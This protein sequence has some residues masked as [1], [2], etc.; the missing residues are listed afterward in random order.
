MTQRCE[1]QFQ[2]PDGNLQWQELRDV[3]SW[4]EQAAK[5]FQRVDNV[6]YKASDDDII[7][8]GLAVPEETD[9]IT[10]DIPECPENYCVKVT[11]SAITRRSQSDGGSAPEL[12]YAFSNHGAYEDFKKM[13]RDAIRSSN[14]DHIF[15]TNHFL[16]CGCESFCM[17]D[18]NTE[19]YVP[20]D[21]TCYVE[22]LCG[23]RVFQIAY[24]DDYPEEN[25]ADWASTGTANFMDWFNECATAMYGCTEH[26]DSDRSMFQGT[27]YTTVYEPYWKSYPK[28]F[29]FESWLGADNVYG[30]GG[31]LYD[32]F[33]DSTSSSEP[34]VAWTCP[35][36]DHQAQLAYF[37]NFVEQAEFARDA[38]L[39][40]ILPSIPCEPEI[41]DPPEPPVLP[42]PTGPGCEEVDHNGY[43]TEMPGATC[44][45]AQASVTCA[46][47]DFVLVNETSTYYFDDV[48]DWT[49]ACLA[50]GVNCERDPRYSGVQGTLLYNGAPAGYPLYIGL[51]SNTSAC[52]SKST[53][54]VTVHTDSWASENNWKL[55]KLKIDGEWEEGGYVLEASNDL[56]YN[57]HLHEDILCLESGRTYRWTLFDSYGD[58]LCSYQGCGS[59]SVTL[60]GVE[61][62]SGDEFDNQV[63]EEFTTPVDHSDDPGWTYMLGNRLNDNRNTLDGYIYYSCESWEGAYGALNFTEGA[64]DRF[65]V[66]GNSYGDLFEIESGEGCSFSPTSSPSESPSLSSEPSNA[67]T[68]SPTLCGESY[69]TSENL[70]VALVVDLSYSTYEKEFSSSVDI[71]D[72]NGDGKGNTI[73]DAQIVAIQD[74]LTSIAESPTLNNDNCEIELISF[75][76]DA[77]DHG[78]WLP[79][80]DSG[81]GF[82]ADL[83][84]Y[85]K[86][87]LRAPTSNDDIFATNNGF[88][89]F[90]NAL[91]VTVDYFQNSAT[92][93]R[94]NLLVF[95]SDGEPNV[96]GDG[97]NEGY[98][99][100]T[101]VFWNGDDTVLQ[102]SDLGLA[103][104]ERHEICR[105]D[106]PMCVEFEP[107]Q[108]CVRGPNECM[109]ADAV[110]Q[111]DSEISALE[112]LNV[113]RLAI[114][115]GDESN[116]AW[117]SALWMID[118]NPGKDLGVLPLKAL[119]LEEL[120]EY[121]SSL[122]ILNTDPPTGSPS[123]SP[124]ASPTESSAPSVAPSDQP[125]TPAPTVTPS[126]LPYF[127]ITT[128]EPTVAPSLSPTNLPTPDPT[129]APSSTPTTSEPTTSPTAS[130]SASPT[131]APTDSPTTTPSAAPSGSFIPSLFPTDSPTTSS[132]PSNTPT[133]SPSEIP[134]GEPTGSPSASPSD[135][136]TTS[137]SDGPTLTPSTFPT[138]DP[139]ASFEPTYV[140][141]DCFEGPRMV[142]ADSSDITMC[143][144]N[145]DM[146]QIN[147]MSTTDVTVQI[148]NVWTRSALPEQL[149]VFAHTDSIDAILDRQDGNGF[150]CLNNDG[151]D[152]DIEGENELSVQC[153]Q[154]SEDS[155]W[156]AVI[157][158]VIT[159]EIICGTNDVPHPCFP[160]EGPILESCS[161]RIIIPCE[162]EAIC[163]EEPTTSPSNSPTSEPTVSPTDYPTLS[164]TTSPTA[165]PTESPTSSPTSSPTT[166]PT[167]GPTS[168]PTESPIAKPTTEPTARFTQLEGSEDNDDYGFPPAECPDDIQ[169]IQH[170]GV[171]DLPDHAVRIVSQDNSTVTVQLVQAYTNAS[172]A[173]GSWYYQYQQGIFSNKCY[174]DTNVVGDDIEEIT[175]QCTHH[176]QIALLEFWISDDI[177]NGVLAEGD[178][179]VIPECCH[180]SEPDGTPAT[181]YVI[182]IRCETACPEV[183]E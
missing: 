136:P 20:Y 179:A 48:A 75:E 97:D 57:H 93:N 165:V 33:P 65:D 149:R 66:F 144:Y 170:T 47:V 154:E 55:E 169:V 164:P 6:G 107:L 176:N 37:G 77:K 9:L 181:R 153:F 1:Y 38:G 64:G 28:E 74:L 54:N 25:K 46:E 95:L 104:G 19:D 132:K 99:T 92:P 83:M 106:D 141:P 27:G 5:T 70:N 157:D 16:R 131:S 2:S 22:E 162:H 175:I 127:V 71:G 101:T 112:A 159:D 41:I 86:N 80:D 108:D 96:R 143:Y 152:I 98:C 45:T 130:P 177:T 155:A 21:A 160:D 146:V 56:L 68:Q 110:I 23:T 124:S 69:L 3:N 11:G 4:F 133:E 49:D 17:D 81:L 134:T 43:C 167:A 30:L 88:T 36:L 119:N 100:D 116:T 173:I 151:T 161:W 18:P 60:D 53:L 59:Y 174:G 178:N 180:P 103:P 168:N 84:T 163:T 182:Q 14:K 67:P 12:L 109:N 129:S 62:A 82:N 15:L 126:E 142:V 111:Y 122:C 128:P 183:V 58:G 91:D 78:K 172:T 105:G 121:L 72:V 13:M 156:L 40:T 140:L 29:N 51:D 42:P 34:V 158:V 113:E 76:T 61:I 73:L 139:T 90:D 52:G 135:E 39:L 32:G 102:C 7:F 89:N 115:V 145:Q 120:T 138:S 114:G 44:Y 147:E 123:Y 79:L 50:S 63:V 117:G 8:S 125:S 85:I 26:P 118:N 150:Q 31:G 87:E 148:N 10:G 137:P 35:T 166:T 171:T 94:K 24:S